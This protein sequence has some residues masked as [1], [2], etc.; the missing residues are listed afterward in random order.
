MATLKYPVW[1]SDEKEYLNDIKVG[2]GT[3]DAIIGKIMDLWK[4]A[5][6][7]WDFTLTGDLEHGLTIRATLKPTT[8]RAKELA[9]LNGEDEQ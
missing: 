8:N 6:Q 7:G 2:E 1:L 3:P 5:R 4:N 9:K